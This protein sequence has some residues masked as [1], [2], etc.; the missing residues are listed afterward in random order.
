[1]TKE[2]GEYLELFENTERGLSPTWADEINSSPE[3]PPS[4]TRQRRKI[5]ELSVKIPQL[6]CSAVEPFE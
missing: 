1:M 4:T 2:A 5:Y 6:P 3:Y